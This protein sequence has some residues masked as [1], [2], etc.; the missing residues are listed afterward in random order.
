MVV[1]IAIGVP[2]FF[3]FNRCPPV[4]SMALHS[5][6]DYPLAKCFDGSSAAYYFRPGRDTNKFVI[7]LMGVFL[8]DLSSLIV[9]DSYGFCPFPVRDLPSGL[10][11][12]ARRA[13]WH[14]QE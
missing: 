7:H 11:G 12:D 9:N 10:W 6:E 1:L 2:V 14:V 13:L 5:L 4:P 8:L 3:V